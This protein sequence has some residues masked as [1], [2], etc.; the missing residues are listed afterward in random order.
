MDLNVIQPYEQVRNLSLRLCDEIVDITTKPGLPDWD[1]VPPGTEFLAQY[2]NVHPSDHVLLFGCHHGALS[3]YIARHNPGVKLDV[4]DNNHIAL[5]MNLGSLKANH[6]SPGTTISGT[7]IPQDDRQRYAVVLMHLPKGRKLARRWLLQ[8]YLALDPGGTLYIAGSNKAGIQSVIKDAMALFGNGHLLAYKKGNR[9]ALMIK[10]FI[11]LPK[12]DWAF[13]PGIAPGTWVEFS[14]T[15]SN[16]SFQIH[17]LPGVFSFDHLDA[18]T[19]MLLSAVRVRP[20]AKVLDVGCGNGVVGLFAASQGAGWVDF[21]DNDLL[22]IASCTETLEM[23]RITNAPVPAGDLLHPISSN[24]Y[25]LIL[26]N[27]PFHAG[28]A[29]DYQ[30]AQALIG[31]SYQALNAG[32]QM[33]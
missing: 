13:A 3:V 4:T 20:G 32:G 1:Q 23:N 12:P 16:L 7:D 26:S 21:I 30:I 15:I 5:E 24:K 6:I 27:P 22:A 28:Q 2:S 33:P 10:E 31:Q 8:A 25:D 14:I 18:G 17:S 19:Q 11:D 29:V 9:I